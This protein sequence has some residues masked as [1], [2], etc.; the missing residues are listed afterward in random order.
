MFQC[1]AGIPSSIPTN[2][3]WSNWRNM[4]FATLVWRMHRFVESLWESSPHSLVPGCCA[5]SSC[6]PK[7]P[8]KHHHKQK[9]ANDRTWS[10][11]NETSRKNKMCFFHGKQLWEQLFLATNH[12]NT[13]ELHL[14]SALAPPKFQWRP[15]QQTSTCPPSWRWQA[16]TEL[17]PR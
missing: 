10:C 3:T 16:S 2:W 6:Q 11:S 17:W 8:R 15:W 7:N 5:I 12:P 9:L 14:W 1:S 13:S 4:A